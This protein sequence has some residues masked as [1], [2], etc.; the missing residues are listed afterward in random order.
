MLTSTYGWNRSNTV[1][2][3]SRLVSW[4]CYKKSLDKG[5]IIYITP[6]Q[7][8]FSFSILIGTNHIFILQGIF[9]CSYVHLKPCKLENE[10]YVRNIRIIYWNSWLLLLVFNIVELFGFEGLECCSI[11]KS[12]FYLSII[13]ATFQRVKHNIIHQAKT[14]NLIGSVL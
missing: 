13:T 6:F 1:S 10:G 3:V 4:I 12:S 14:R 7:F 8:W 2:C 9:P 5:M 11:W